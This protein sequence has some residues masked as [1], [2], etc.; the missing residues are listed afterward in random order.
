MVAQKIEDQSQLLDH[1]QTIIT[2]KFNIGKSYT[3]IQGSTKEEK[4]MY[5]KK[6]LESYLWIRDY[7]REVVTKLGGLTKEMSDILKNCE[8]MVELLPSK[9]DHINA[10]KM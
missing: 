10:E 8:E 5:L 9:I 6:G 2:T 1:H 7:I 3:R 4:V